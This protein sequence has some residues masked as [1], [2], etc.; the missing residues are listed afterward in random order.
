MIKIQGLEYDVLLVP[1]GL[2]SNYVGQTM[3]DDLLI[4]VSD[5][6]AAQKQEQVLIHEITHMLMNEEPIIT[7]QAHDEAEGFVSRVATILYETLVEND[8]LVEGWFEKLV[9]KRSEEVGVNVSSPN[10]V[11][12]NDPSNRTTEHGPDESLRGNSNDEK[13]LD[14]RQGNVGRYRSPG[15]HQRPRSRRRS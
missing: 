11:E 13:V 10:V 1:Q 8:L 5:S 9:D 7:G 12:K 3:T 15:F 14:G 6:I 4:M 2:H